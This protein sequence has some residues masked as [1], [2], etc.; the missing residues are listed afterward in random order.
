[1]RTLKSY[2]ELDMLD[3]IALF[4]IIVKSG[5]LKAA[6]KVSKLPSA[7][8]SR[9]LKN[10]EKQLSCRLIHRNSHRFTV[11]NEGQKLY[12]QSAYLLESLDTRLSSFRSE[13]SGSSGPIK[14]LAPLS[15]VTSTLQPIFTSFLELNSDVDLHL[16][17]SNDL[18]SFLASGADFAIRVGTQESSELSQI[19]LGE[20]QTLLVASPYYASK[21]SEKLTSPD[22]LSHCQLIISNPMSKWQLQCKS[23]NK[24]IEVNQNSA[25]IIGS[26]GHP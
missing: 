12:Q 8:V 10:L 23:S 25:K 21:V 14:V 15:L 16:E 2:M 17:L 20:I 13:I 4:V 26:S 5:S 3:D 1:M 22:E 9:R 11:T 24:K 19:K 7:T 6:A 18:T